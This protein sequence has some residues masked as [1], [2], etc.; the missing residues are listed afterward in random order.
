[1]AVNGEYA[2]SAGYAVFQTARIPY[3]SEILQHVLDA[4][5]LATVASELVKGAGLIPMFQ[6]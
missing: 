2:C 4:Y 1:M 3:E 6:N 5:R